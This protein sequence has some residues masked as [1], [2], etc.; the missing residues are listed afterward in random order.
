MYNF[1]EQKGTLISNVVCYIITFVLPCF[2]FVTV[3][4][5]TDT[6]LCLNLRLCC[7]FL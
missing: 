4:K 5:L 6:S 7:F 2:E 1:D 3:Y